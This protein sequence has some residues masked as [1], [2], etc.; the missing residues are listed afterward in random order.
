V[1]DSERATTETQ[2]ASKGAN[3]T[4]PDVENGTRRRLRDSAPQAKTAIN[5]LALGLLC[6]W[7]TSGSKFFLTRPNVENVLS[8]VSLVAII[9]C[10]MTLLLVAGAFDLSVGGVVALSGCVSAWLSLHGTSVPLSFLAGAATGLAVGLVNS[11]LVVLLGINSL[12]ATIGTMYVCR[13]FA[14]LLTGGVAL[15]GMSQ[16]YGNLGNTY[17]GT[18]PITVIYM[19]VFV[20]VFS[21]A[22]RWTLLGRY[23]VASGSNE[24]AAFLSGVPVRRTRTLCFLLT[25]AAAG[26]AGIMVSS[27]LTAGVPDA[28]TGLEFEVIVAAVV[29]GAS[30]FGGEGRVT[31][32]L[33]GALIIG[34]LNNGLDLTNVRSYWQ[35]V[36]LGFVLVVAVGLDILLRHPDV[37]RVARL[38]ASPI[39]ALGRGQERIRDGM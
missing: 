9:G 21:V 32:T 8:Q 33:L 18:V 3:H 39:S 36:T 19:L 13:G 22:E 11:V 24:E 6:A 34:V 35:T 38:V 2:A 31:G 16:S 29:G 10:A 5:L 4:G 28:G 30:L 25:G 37:M 23:A 26:F 12:I 27:Q 1:T 17:L 14:L 20:V 15:G 7:A